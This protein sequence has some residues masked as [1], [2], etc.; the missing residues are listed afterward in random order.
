M[1]VLSP[2]DFAMQKQELIRRIQEGAVFLYPTDTVYGLGCDAT[3]SQSVQRLRALKRS[4]QPFSVI[5]PSRKWVV[6]NCLVDKSA[7]RWLSR[8]PGP[9]TLI[10]R[11]RRKEAV[12]EEV[13]KGQD[14]LGIRIPKHWF[15]KIISE[16]AIPVVTTSANISGEGYMT[17]MGD[18]DAGI[19]SGVDFILYEGKKGTRPSTLVHLTGSAPV[20]KRR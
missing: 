17:S 2:E 5:A 9:Y 6:E 7:R 3:N 10:L 4:R 20:V 1:L 12:S 18:V 16:M 19:R 15:S 8:L 11:L 14:T 13:N